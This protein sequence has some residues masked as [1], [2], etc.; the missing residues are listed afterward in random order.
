MLGKH[1]LIFLWWNISKNELFT[2]FIY[3]MVAT[4]FLKGVHENARKYAQLEPKLAI[5]KF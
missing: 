4:N 3:L 5:S 1:Y 2:V